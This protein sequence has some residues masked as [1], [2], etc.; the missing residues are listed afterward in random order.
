MTQAEYNK[1]D[2]QKYENLQAEYKE[3][4]GEYENIKSDDPIDSK[5]VEKV[6]EIAGKQKETQDLAS[7]LSQK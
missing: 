3:L 1:E 7:K 6:K 5:L 2:V 4:F